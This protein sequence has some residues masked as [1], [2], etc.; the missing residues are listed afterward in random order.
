MA[1]LRLL[2]IPKVH[3]GTLGLIS[4][5][6]TP[7]TVPVL[8]SLV[9]KNTKPLEP[10]TGIDT[11]LCEHT[12]D[13]ENAFNVASYRN[14]LASDTMYTSPFPSTDTAGCVVE[15]GSNTEHN[16]DPDDV[17]RPYTFNPP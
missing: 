14:T 16:T 9:T 11:I 13:E 12:K 17:D 1:P 3:T 6:F 15:P 7:I 8:P 5:M 4:V 2:S 10:T